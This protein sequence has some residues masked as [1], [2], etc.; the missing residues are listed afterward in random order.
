MQD[1]VES[2]TEEQDDV[3]A[4]K[5]DGSGGGYV[6]RMRVGENTFALGSWEERDVGSEDG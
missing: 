5:S 3:S 4:A 2:G 6:E 1:P